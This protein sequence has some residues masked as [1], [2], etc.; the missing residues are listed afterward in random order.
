MVCEAIGRLFKRKD[1]K[2]MAYLPK[3]LVEDSAFPFKIGSSLQV[4]MKFNERQ[5]IIEKLEEK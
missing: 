5:I 2:Y 3:N 4:K 1:N